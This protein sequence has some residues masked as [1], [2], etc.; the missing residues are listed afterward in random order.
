RLLILSA[1]FTALEQRGYKLV[2][3]TPYRRVVQVE[4]GSDCLEVDVRERMQ[5]VRR[6]LTDEEHRKRGFLSTGRK[7]WTQEQHATGEL[8]AGI[9]EGHSRAFVVQWRESA[10]R[11]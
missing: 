3:E 8:V 9:R 6:P 5:Q 10:D 1:L 4:H 7:R 11:P 2:V